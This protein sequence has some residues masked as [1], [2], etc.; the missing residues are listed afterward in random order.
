[1]TSNVDKDFI[2][3]AHR[4]TRRDGSLV[5]IQPIVDVSSKVG[6]AGGKAGIV[7]T[8]RADGADRAALSARDGNLPARPA[9][10]F[11]SH[12][13]QGIWRQLHMKELTIPDG[14]T[15]EELER[16]GEIV[17]AWERGDDEFAEDFRGLK[18]VARLFEYLRGAAS[19]RTG[20]K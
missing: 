15:F 6:Q 8:R 17:F 3:G 2:T 1:M 14:L 20:A 12:T 5:H 7:G 19:A 4:P 9:R 18:L 13:R 10:R 16:G 11:S